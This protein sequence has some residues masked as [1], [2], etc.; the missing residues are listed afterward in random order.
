MT[1]AVTDF[2]GETNAGNVLPW[3]SQ[4][5]YENA[6]N[7]MTYSNVDPL[8][9]MTQKSGNV[10]LM[11]SELCF[12]MWAKCEWTYR[13]QGEQKEALGI[14]SQSVTAHTEDPR[15]AR[16]RHLFS[17]SCL[18]LS[19]L[20]SHPYTTAP[21]FNNRERVKCEVSTCWCPTSLSSI[22]L[23]FLSSMKRQN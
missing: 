21:T 4:F 3:K 1:S 18:R 13:A 8:K 7:S 23:A 22:H 17:S 6:L 9:S 11:Y 5:I 12:I 15:A 14:L 19:P 2:F 20:C 10:N 16:D